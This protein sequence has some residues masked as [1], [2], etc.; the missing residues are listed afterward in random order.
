MIT[1]IFGPPRIG[2][3][4]FLV[5]QLNC[6]AFDFERNYAMQEAIKEKNENGFNLTLPEH[7]ASAN[8]DV[9]FQKMDYSERNV[10]ILKMLLL[11]EL[12]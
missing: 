7:C 3:T 2:K 4:A 11:L 8:F 10:F 5:Y 12:T 1:I 6:A 9:Q